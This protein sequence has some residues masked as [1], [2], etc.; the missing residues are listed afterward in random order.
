MTS[1]N[2]ES[3]KKICVEAII[4]DPCGEIPTTIAWSSSPSGVVSIN[5]PP[6]DKYA[7][8]T[9]IGNP[10][11]ST[12]VTVTMDGVF[13]SSF[14]MNIITC[15]IPV[16]EGGLEVNNVPTNNAIIGN[17]IN[18]VTF[19]VIPTGN[20]VGT[21]DGQTLTNKTFNTP[22]ITSNPITDDTG[23]LI[24][25]GQTTTTFDFTPNAN[26][27][28]SSTAIITG[29]RT[30]RLGSGMISNTLGTLP[31][32]V[33]T[34][35]WN[36]HEDTSL[37][38][39]MVGWNSSINVGYRYW[40]DNGQVMLCFDIASGL[41]ATSGVISSSIALPTFLI[42]A[43]TQFIRVPIRSNSTTNNTIGRLSITNAGIVTVSASV[44][45]G[46]FPSTTASNQNGW[47]AVLNI[48]YFL[49]P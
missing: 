30:V 23:N 6:N 19:K 45:G 12:T 14:T 31:S 28:L 47:A 24:I 17:G 34:F 44:S 40:R 26:F 37:T 25:S 29:S 13:T 39:N 8:I 18:P 3:C 21:T 43:S 48:M 9:A 27:S 7:I 35:I 32:L 22:N 41:M 1:Y 20:F 4:S 15:L 2:L 46:N 33:S 38:I 5:S 36:S 11:D 10:G 16:E 42:P 49:S